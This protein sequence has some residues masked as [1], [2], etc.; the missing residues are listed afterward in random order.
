M[1]SNPQTS[2]DAHIAQV[3]LLK[4]EAGITQVVFPSNRM[5]DISKLSKSC[6]QALRIMSAGELEQLL[7]K[8][9]LTELPIVSDNSQVDTYLDLALLKQSSDIEV[10]STRENSY[11]K[12]SEDHLEELTSHANLGDFSIVVT[13]EQTPADVSQDIQ[14][15]NQAVSQFTSRRISQR[16]EETLDIPPLPEISQKIIDLRL[17]PN[18]DGVDLARAIELDPSLSAQIL[19][20]ARSPYY[21]A[22]GNITSVEEAVNRVLGFDLVLNLTLGLALSRAIKLPRNGPA[23]YSPFWQQA[24]VTAS[25]CSELARKIPFKVRPVPGLAYLSGLLHNFGFMVIGHTFPQQ[26][27]QINRHIEANPHINR[28]HIE[29]HI[30]GMTREQCSACLLQQW[31]L[32]SELVT[33]VRH[34]HTYGFEGEHA[35]YAKILY[36]AVRLLRQQGIGD[37]PNDLISTQVYQDLQLKPLD[38]EATLFSLIERLNDLDDLIRIIQGSNKS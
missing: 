12:L 34:Q 38:A 35:A 33:A 21:S 29:Q 6:D 3:T 2:Y 8:L 30:L 36:L 1:Q 13:P 32:P 28:M 7:T 15:I 22:H 20:W 11:T 27:E 31:E 5:L 4:H 25:L 10:A 26:F 18:A 19:S 17:D 16:L 14:Q 9:K 23:G 24:I 37:G